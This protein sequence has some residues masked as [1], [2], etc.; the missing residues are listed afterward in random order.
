MC[1]HSRLSYIEIIDSTVW[2]R[3]R[4]NTRSDKRRGSGR[5]GGL[6]NCD[7]HITGCDDGFKSKKTSAPFCHAAAAAAL[8]MYDISSQL[9]VFAVDDSTNRR[10]DGKSS[11]L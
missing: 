10:A 6:R 7:I 1:L 3:Y 5:I 8:A 9:L 2:I 4:L 11:T